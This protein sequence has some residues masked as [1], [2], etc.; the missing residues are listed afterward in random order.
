MNTNEIYFEKVSFDEFRETFEKGRQIAPLGVAETRKIW[1]AIPLPC[2]ATAGSAGYDFFL[3]YEIEVLPEYPLTLP[4]GIRCHMPPGVVLAIVPKSGL[5]FKYG[6]RLRNSTGI[7]DSDY[8][9][10]SNEGHIQ[11]KLT[12][13]EP[14]R[15]PG[16]AKFMQG[17]FL[18]YL[19]A[20]ND[21][22]SG[23]RNGGFGSTGV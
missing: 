8:Y 13:E 21:T 6:L 10:S 12:A 17:I 4:T 1:E 20:A 19:T 16:C 14:V 23:V 5:G 3:P 7:V 2:R 22:A 15:L 18:P 9:Y 11:A